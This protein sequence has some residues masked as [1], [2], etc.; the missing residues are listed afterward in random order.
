MP[1]HLISDANEW[2]DEI[3]TVPIF[4]LANQQQRERALK[5]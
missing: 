2:I 5:K 3:P 1:R 4:Y